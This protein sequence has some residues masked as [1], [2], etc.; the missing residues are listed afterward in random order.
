[1]V[2]G[3]RRAESNLYGGPNWDFHDNS[4]IREARAKESENFERGNSMSDRLLT[5]KELVKLD[6]D[7]A[8]CQAQDTKSYPLGEE[9][10]IAKGRAEVVAFI[11][12]EY[13]WII[14]R[15]QLKEWG[16]G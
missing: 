1:M 7:K 4:S 14:P 9:A 11:D 8:I 16:L 15:E 6:S 13:S 12:K 5:W 3:R 10:G 2:G